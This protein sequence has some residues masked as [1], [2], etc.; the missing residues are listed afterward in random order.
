MYVECRTDYYTNLIRGV[1]IKKNQKFFSKRSSLVVYV[2]RN[3]LTTNLIGSILP[4][5]D[6][7]DVKG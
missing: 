6:I 3:N 7:I 1:I 2:A 4:C 5:F